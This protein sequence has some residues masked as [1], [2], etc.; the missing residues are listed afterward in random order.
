MNFSSKQAED[1][2]IPVSIFGTFIKIDLKFV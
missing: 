2:I 1:Q